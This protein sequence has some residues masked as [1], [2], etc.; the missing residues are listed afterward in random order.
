MNETDKI[1]LGCSLS[2]PKVYK[3]CYLN[4]IMDNKIVKVGIIA[5]LVLGIFI[6]S[7]IILKPMLIPIIFG[8][9]SA[10]IFNPVY[11]K[12]NKI[13]PSKNL[14]ALVLIIG[15]TFLVLFPLVYFTP[16]LVR[17]TFDTY[18]SVQNF[19]F[20]KYFQ[21]FVEPS[22]ADTIARNVDNILGKLFSTLLNQFSAFLI[23]LPSI[24]LQFI[25]YLFTFFFTVR[26]S[27]KLK[28]Y[29]H[30]LS[31]FSD[32]TDKKLLKEFRG[33]T[34]AIIYG[35]VLIG[36]LQGLALGLGLFILGIPKAL[37]LTFIAMLFSVI[38]VLG[39]WVVWL[40]VGL[41]QI[42]L[43]NTFDGVFLLFYGALFVSTID[44]FVRPY[45]LSK[46]SNLPIVISIIG[47]I[48]GF[49]VYG[50]LGLILGPLILAY[51]LII[52]EFYKEGKL[53]ELFKR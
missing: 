43:G 5:T 2:S 39:S 23:N 22:V 15:L 45:L 13:I 36:V 4:N 33:I 1:N 30:T 10:Y 24:L 53:D 7:F 42:S 29:L 32:N 28:I 19:D 18:A 31:P 20:T 21:K 34:N 25:V 26:D 16:T 35:Q 51:L 27:E 46:G 3:L 38:P 47:T 41:L 40:P 48:G 14:S 12:I 37:I 49:Y 11:K 9:L 44:N 17:Q 50:I 52:I 6:L 8:L